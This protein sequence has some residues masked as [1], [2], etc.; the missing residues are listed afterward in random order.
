MSH[1]MIETK[2]N[3]QL[4]DE[5]LI[6]KVIDDEYVNINHMVLPKG[7]ALPLHY[8]NSIVHMIVVRG[9]VTLKLDEQPPIAYGAGS[10]LNIPFN[11]HMDVSNQQDE[12][13]EFFVVKAPN[14]RNYKK[15]VK[16]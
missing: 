4:T 14:P 1:K 10:I 3:Y 12:I 11:T 8:S 9:N 2:F 6:E 15:Y 16:E 13:A 7:D 5:K